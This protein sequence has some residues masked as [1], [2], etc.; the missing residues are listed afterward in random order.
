M[1]RTR[2][3]GIYR[4]RNAHRLRLCPLGPQRQF[5][6]AVGDARLQYIIIT[7]GKRFRPGTGVQSRLYEPAAGGHE[8][9][10]LLLLLYFLHYCPDA[11]EEKCLKI[12]H[13]DLE[14]M[15]LQ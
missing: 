13:S 15:F 1:V 12:Q 2:L 5:E 10:Q 6:T 8:R 4:Y 7:G 9:E 14:N 11:I 3:Q